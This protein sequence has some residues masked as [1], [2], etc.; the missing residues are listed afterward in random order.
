MSQ[1]PNIEECVDQKELSISI[2]GLW[3][4]QLAL[5]SIVKMFVRI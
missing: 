2:Y 1:F 3:V 4:S 5:G